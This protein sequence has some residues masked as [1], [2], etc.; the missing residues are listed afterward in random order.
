MC[1]V[2]LLYAL[3]PAHNLGDNRVG[4]R[5]DLFWRLVLDRMRDADHLVVGSSERCRLRARRGQE[6]MRCHGHGR[7]P[8]SLQRQ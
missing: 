8:Q 3:Q 2:L 1:G 7:D 5:G 4:S 6:L